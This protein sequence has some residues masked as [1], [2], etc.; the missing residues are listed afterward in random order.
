MKKE[1]FLLG[2]VYFDQETQIV[3]TNHAKR[4]RNKSL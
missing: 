4:K 1:F 2:L 3:V